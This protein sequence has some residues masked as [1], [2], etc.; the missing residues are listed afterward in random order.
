M[1]VEINLLKSRY[2][3]ECLENEKEKIISNA[4]KIDL[5][6]NKLKHALG[7]IDEKTLLVLCSLMLQAELNKINLKNNSSTKS[8]NSKFNEDDIYDAISENIDNMNSY[9]ERLITKIQDY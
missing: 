5:K 4:Q 7:D 3:I 6:L 2:K 8:D 1:I 9:I